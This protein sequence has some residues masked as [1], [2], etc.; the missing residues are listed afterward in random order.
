MINQVMI[1]MSIINGIAVGIEFVP[2]MD[3]R[4][5]GKYPNTVVLDIFVI[6]LIFQWQ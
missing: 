6:R 1:G 5:L 4:E 3:D 2:S